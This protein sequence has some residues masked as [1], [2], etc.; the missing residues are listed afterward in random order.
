MGVLREAR[1]QERW[2]AG[3]AGGGWWTQ[4]LHHLNKIKIIIIMQCIM[5]SGTVSAQ[6]PVLLEC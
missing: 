6:E 4:L 5:Q 2:A 3:A 1:Q